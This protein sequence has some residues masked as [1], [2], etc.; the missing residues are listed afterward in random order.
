[1]LV[2]PLSVDSALVG[3]DTAEGVSPERRLMSHP[4]VTT[5]T[6]LCS[7]ILQHNMLQHAVLHHA[8]QEW[9]LRV[10]SVALTQELRTTYA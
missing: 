8:G 10:A 4:S 7:N 5:A 2:L 9:S 3:K 1:L 6:E